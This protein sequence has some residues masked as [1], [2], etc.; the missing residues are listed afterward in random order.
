MDLRF[1][2]LAHLV[3][4]LAVVGWVLWADLTGYGVDASGPWWTGGG[5]LAL[6]LAAVVL[7]V[8]GVPAACLEAWSVRTT[9]TRWPARL[10]LSL[11]AGLAGLVAFGVT[12][13]RL[14][15]VDTPTDLADLVLGGLAFLPMVAGQALA[16]RALCRIPFPTVR[17]G[18]GRRVAV[19]LGLVEE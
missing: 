19:R 2:W 18:R 8:L 5:D 9:S 15:H 6:A 7:V 13:L 1:P 4:G 12:D 16:A 11:Y 17:S 3:A 10:L 14:A